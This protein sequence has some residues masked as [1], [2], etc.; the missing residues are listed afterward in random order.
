MNVKSLIK[1]NLAICKKKGAMVLQKL[2][3]VRLV[4]LR[5][6]TMETVATRRGRPTSANVTPDFPKT[7]T[8]TQKNVKVC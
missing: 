1:K 3:N 2:M 7:Q 5:V 8:L 6:G 4:T